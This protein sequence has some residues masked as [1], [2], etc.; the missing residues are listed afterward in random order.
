MI[1]ALKG[2]NDADYEMRI[3]NSDGSEPEMCG[4]GLRCM[5]KFLQKLEG[6]DGQETSYDIWTL[7]GMIKPKIVKDGSVEV[8]MGFGKLR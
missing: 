8:D 3:Y 2:K 4:N 7:A 1:F 6:K 5:A